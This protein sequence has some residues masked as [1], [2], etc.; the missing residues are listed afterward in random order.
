VKFGGQG[1]GR[2]HGDIRHF[3]SPKNHRVRN[4]DTSQAVIRRKSCSRLAVAIGT[5]SEKAPRHQP[6]AEESNLI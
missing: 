3:G 1:D 4:R 5:E 6:S 2:I